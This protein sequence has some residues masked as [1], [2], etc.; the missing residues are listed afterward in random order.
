MAL[1]L[2]DRVVSL[3]RGVL[4]AKLEHL[5]AL[6]TLLHPVAGVLSAPLGVEA[7]QA[8]LQLV[9]LLVVDVVVEED[10]LVLQLARDLYT[11][12]VGEGHVEEGVE[13]LA[14]LGAH[15]DWR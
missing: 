5:V 2:E 6:A 4:A 11:G 7:P 13:G 1:G 15:L 8:F 12:L 9:E 3:A 10:I 14:V